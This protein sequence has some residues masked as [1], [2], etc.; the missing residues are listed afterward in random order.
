[1]ELKKTA[2]PTLR[3]LFVQQLVGKIF[4]GELRAGD[5]LPSEREMSEKLGISRSMVHLGLEDLE[6]MGFVRIEPRRG[7]YATDYAR[8]GNFETFAALTRYGGALDSA[9]EVSLVEM[10][11]AVYGGGLI[12]LS[13]EHTPEDIAALRAQTQRLRRLAQENADAKSCAVE[14]RR[15]ET[16]VTELGGNALFPLIMN[17][18][19]EACQALWERCVSFWG[20]NEVAAQEEHIIE[21]ISEGKGHE[22]ALYI[23]DIYRRYQEANNK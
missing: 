18:F 23:E 12:R 14:M 19:G 22:A 13:S 6:R 9:L 1:M 11:N 10:R 7:I 8:E 5:K 17:A 2:A 21:L 3:E 15:F 4:S 20:A 16:L